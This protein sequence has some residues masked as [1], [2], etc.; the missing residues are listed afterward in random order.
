MRVQNKISVD[1]VHAQ[2]NFKVAV[3]LAGLSIFARIVRMIRMDEKKRGGSPCIMRVALHGRTRMIAS[4]IA[5][6]SN[7]LI[8]L[9]I[10]ANKGWQM[11]VA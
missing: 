1:G 9:N 6:A 2:D 3:R 4:Q 11:S 8:I 7:I 5:F 10:L